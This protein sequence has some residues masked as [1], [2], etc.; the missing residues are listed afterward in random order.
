MSGYTLDHA[1]AEVMNDKLMSKTGQRDSYLRDHD[2]YKACWDAM[3]KWIESRLRKN[4][5]A[6]VGTF[7]TF[8]WDFREVD[9]QKQC[10]PIF[11]VSDSFVKEH[12]VQRPQTRMEPI[13]AKSEEI[14]YSKLAIKFSKSLTKD[15]I[16]SGLRDLLHKIGDYVDRSYEFEIEFSFGTLLSKER[17]IRFDF[18]FLRLTQILPETMVGEARSQQMGLSAA[19]KRSSSSAGS[20]LGKST[21]RPGTTA[22]KFPRRNPGLSGQ[23]LPK[24]HS[25]D[26]MLDTHAGMDLSLNLNT[27]DD[28]MAAEEQTLHRSASDGGGG[29]VGGGTGGKAADTGI[30][31]FSS[32]NIDLGFGDSKA[33]SSRPISPGLQQLLQSMDPPSPLLSKHDRHALACQSVS[34]QAFRRCLFSVQEEQKDDEYKDALIIQMQIDA[35]MKDQVKKLKRVDEVNKLQTTLY[36]QMEGK[37]QLEGKPKT[38]SATSLIINPK[39]VEKPRDEG[40]LLGLLTEQ[41]EEKRQIAERDKYNKLAEESRF[42]E[43]VAVEFDVQNTV[44]RV[45]HLEKQRALLEDWERAAH[46]RNLKKLKGT[47]VVHKYVTTNFAEQSGAMDSSYAPE[48]GSRGSSRGGFGASVGYDSRK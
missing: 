46:I 47:D 36:S 7:G 16:F 37:K 41:I 12:N 35:Q 3:N 42:L 34:A 10:R 14:N 2:F 20:D 13:L 38:P 33:S 45:H 6:T 23:K 30:V 40:K 27:I 18:N 15:M 43:H 29:G 28:R 21:G 22:K 17:R 32:L 39:H 48:T 31:D 4:K 44:E 1:I 24:M 5:G 8:S 9:G 25:T 26:A 11:L 19:P